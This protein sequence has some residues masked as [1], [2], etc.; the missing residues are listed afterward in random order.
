MDACDAFF[1]NCFL[2]WKG[3]VLRSQSE[4][5]TYFVTHPSIF[6]NFRQAAC[7][8]Y[9]S[10]GKFLFEYGKFPWLS[11][12]SSRSRTLFLF[13]ERLE[14]L[15]CP[16][17]HSNRSRWV[18]FVSFTRK[19]KKNAHLSSLWVR[20]CIVMCR[21]RFIDRSPSSAFSLK[22]KNHKLINV[23]SLTNENCSIS[24][25]HSCSLQRANI[26]S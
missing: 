3:I 2:I 7:W 14:W 12:M 15:N 9:L 25:F 22:L 1:A 8:R 10:P 26:I 20:V 16:I 6:E 11:F 13:L 19:K 18:Y 5:R 23:S 24:P 17:K 21:L 4:H